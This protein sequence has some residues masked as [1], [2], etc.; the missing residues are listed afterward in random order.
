MKKLNLIL[1]IATL[2]LFQSCATIM[3]GSRQYVTFN[4]VQPDAIIYTYHF[5][6]KSEITNIDKSKAIA[7]CKTPATVKIK[8]NTDLIFVSKEGYKDSTIYCS[9]PKVKLKYVDSKT[10]LIT[11]KSIKVSTYKPSINPWYIVNIGFGVGIGSTLFMCIDLATG[12]CYKLPKLMTVNLQK[13]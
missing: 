13:K 12:S 11:K 7:I 9:V 5:K 10:G 3:N 8:R 4:S 2:F 1:F 6:K